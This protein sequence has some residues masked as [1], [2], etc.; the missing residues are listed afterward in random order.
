MKKVYLEEAIKLSAENVITQ[1]GGPFGCVI[2]R[3]GEIVGR[4]ANRVLVD[5]DPSA[6]AE[7]V[8]IRDACKNLNNHQLTDC[9]V[10]TSCEPCPMCLSA[11]YWARP[12][13]VYFANTKEDAAN[14]GFDDAFIYQQLQLPLSERSLKLIQVSIP[15]A[16]KPFQDWDELEGKERY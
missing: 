6:H 10:Y 5:L 14:V 11:L 16:L 4:G 1:N 15:E 3:N 2:V 8:A 9:E 7:I 13:V 12:K